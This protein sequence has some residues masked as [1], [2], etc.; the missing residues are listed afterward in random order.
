MKKILSIFVIVSL[1][2][3]FPSSAFA[4]IN[5]TPYFNGSDSTDASSYVTAVFS[6][7][8]NTLYI[9]S[10]NS[11]TGITADP[12]VPT[13][14][15]AG[16]TWVQVDTSL[17]DPTSSSRRRLTTFR[18]TGTGSAGALTFD[19]AGQIQTSTVW[20]IDACTGV[21]TNNPVIQH[22]TNAYPDTA[23][24][25]LVATSTTLNP[26]LNINNANYTVLSLQNIADT[27][28]VGFT[29]TDLASSSEPV[30]FTQFIRSEYLPTATT[31][32]Y[33][34]VASNPPGSAGFGVIALEL[35]A[36]PNRASVNVSGQ[37]NV[38]GQILIK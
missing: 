11:R 2:S 29:F 35:N 14:T 16:L 32:S 27:A 23:P 4:V 26:F 36:T 1:L 18:A 8:A 25:V 7:S 10:F 34:T 30:E 15:G 17:Y 28:T 20:S 22:S 5:C 19:E 31:T 24:L 38:N 37:I 21:D 3:I 9:A 12:N 6:S 33:F 13:L